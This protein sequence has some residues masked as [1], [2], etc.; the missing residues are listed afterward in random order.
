MRSY[1]PAIA[2]N[3]TALALIFVAFYA[4]SLMA[5]PVLTLWATACTC[6][7]F[8][9]VSRSAAARATGIIA[10]LLLS[11]MFMVFIATK[12]SSY[13]LGNDKFQY[14]QYMQS[15]LNG[16]FWETI[17]TQPEIISFGL[18][19]S[20][21]HLTGVSNSSFAIIFMISFSVLIF[22][23]LRLAGGAA[24][25][26]I[27]L[28]LSSFIVY[29]TYGNVIRQSIAVSFLFLALSLSKQKRAIAL[30]CVFLSHLSAIIFAPFFIFKNTIEKLQSK[31]L[32]VILISVIAYG[33]GSFALSQLTGGLFGSLGY[34]ENKVELYS[35]WEEYDTTKS[36]IMSLLLFSLSCLSRSKIIKMSPSSNVTPKILNTI[37]ELW[38]FSNYIFLF[39]MLSSPISKVFDR[40]YIYYFLISFSYLIMFLHTRKNAQIRNIS[41]AL[42][43]VYFTVYLFK[44]VIYYDQFYCVESTDF[45]FDNIFTMYSCL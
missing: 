7:F 4:L 24:V 9:F 25:P 40:I 1:L 15:F 45:L 19:N 33:V 14:K 21:A 12:D 20:I 38:L 44:N 27:C 35:Q 34:V 17:L 18:I 41:A 23:L 13:F 11:T 26:I 29:T 5:L 31:I 28:I 2:S 36:L 3:N 43:I 10:V 37:N 32:L 6:T 22:S 16:Y 42:L 8:I 39:L 30:V